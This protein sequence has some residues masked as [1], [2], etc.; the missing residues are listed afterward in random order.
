MKEVMTH[1]SNLKIEGDENENEVDS[2]MNKLIE[3]AEIV[4]KTKKK[5]DLKS[6]MMKPF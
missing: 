6:L 5:M 2:K 1:F 4:K 3:Y